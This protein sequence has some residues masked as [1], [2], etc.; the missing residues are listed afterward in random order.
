MTN[1]HIETGRMAV[2]CQNLTLGAP[3][4]RDALFVLVG[5]LF[6]IVVFFF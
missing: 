1:A 6:K 3:S 4:N 2:C 5:A